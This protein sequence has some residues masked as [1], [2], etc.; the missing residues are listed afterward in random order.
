M[1]QAR[2]ADE[3]L[4]HYSD[5]EFQA[6]FVRCW[7]ARGLLSDCV[8]AD[9]WE[10]PDGL[11]DAV[12]LSA[13]GTDWAAWLAS[14]GVD[15]PVATVAVFTSFCRE[16]LFVDIERTNIDSILHDLS[17]EVRAQRIRIPNAFGR[18]SDD[19]FGALFGDWRDSLSRDETRRFLKRVPQGVAQLAD[20]P[21]G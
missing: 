6:R 9:D 7:A 20:V 12:V 13:E 14:E 17:D 1:A 4:E 10:A 3:L 5:A 16:S 21:T 11:A 2:R 18:E 8:L 15:W 19:A